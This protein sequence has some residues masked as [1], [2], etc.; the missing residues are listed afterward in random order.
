MSHPSPI[1]WRIVIGLV[2]IVALASCGGS[3]DTSSD[4]GSSNGDST[5]GAS[6]A[7]ETVTL[8]TK[9]FYFE[10]D[11]VTVAAGSTEIV[12]D[13]SGGM[14]E[15]DFTL[16]ELGVEIYAAP[17]DTEREVVDLESGSYEFFCSIPGHREA[18]MEGTLT[19][20]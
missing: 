13:N 4:D 15:H 10:P 14:V 19:V 16:E 3:D 9:E 17:G 6:S 11:T 2:A 1:V 12:V 7:D 8:V 5:E 20:S 18:G